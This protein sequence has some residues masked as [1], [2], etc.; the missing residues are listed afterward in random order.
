[1]RAPRPPSWQGL[2]RLRGLPFNVTTEAVMQFFQ[3]YHIPNGA[4]GTPAC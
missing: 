2:V 3:G 1:M 4:M